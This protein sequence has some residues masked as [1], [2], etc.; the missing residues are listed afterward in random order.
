MITPQAGDLWKVSFIR[1]N[2]PAE[3]GPDDWPK[4]PNL[5]TNGSYSAT[6]ESRVWFCYNRPHKIMIDWFG[7][8]FDLNPGI[9]DG[10]DGWELI[11]RLK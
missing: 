8:T 10:K 1:E 2:Y 4:N 7:E 11:Y 6:G 3:A 9:E 5:V